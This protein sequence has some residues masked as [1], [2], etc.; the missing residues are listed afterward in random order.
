MLLCMDLS[1]QALGFDDEGFV[2]DFLVV[3]ALWDSHTLRY[4][5]CTVH[6]VLV[7]EDDIQFDD[8]N[9]MMDSLYLNGVDGFHMANFDKLTMALNIVIQI[10]V[11][12]HY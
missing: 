4:C 11:D 9:L 8:D 10:G 2:E 5:D 6:N 1:V 7:F 3:S 12:N